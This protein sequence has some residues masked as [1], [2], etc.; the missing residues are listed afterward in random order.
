M[1]QDTDV[2]AVALPSVKSL[3][4]KFESKD[5]SPQGEDQQ[6]ARS[7]QPDDVFENDPETGGAPDRRWVT[8]HNSLLR[9]EPKSP[10]RQQPRKPPVTAAS[11][12]KRL[13][14]IG[15]SPQDQD[16]AMEV[17]LMTDHQDLRDKSRSEA[18]LRI[19]ASQ[20]QEPRLRTNATARQRPK[21]HRRSK[22]EPDP[23]SVLRFHAQSSPPSV[24]K[25][26][27]LFE[28]DAVPDRSHEPP[29]LSPRKTQR[30]RTPDLPQ[31]V[32]TSRKT[33]QETTVIETTSAEVVH[34]VVSEATVPTKITPQEKVDPLLHGTPSVRSLR[35]RFEIGDSDQPT[36]PTAEPSSRPSRA[37]VNT[38]KTPFE[39]PLPRQARSVSPDKQIRTSLTGTPSASVK[40][41]LKQFEALSP[42]ESLRD[43]SGSPAV[44]E[45]SRRSPL[46][47]SPKKQKAQSLDH[48]VAQDQHDA[49]AQDKITVRAEKDSKRRLLRQSRTSGSSSSSKSSSSS[50][51]DEEETKDNK[52]TERELER[53]RKEE[54]KE[55]Q[56][57]EQEQRALEQQRKE[58][59]EKERKAREEKERKE[60]EEKAR[61]ERE[62]KEKKEREEKERKE[63]EEKARKEREERERKE[64]EEKARKDREERERKEREEKVRKEREEKQKKERE[65]K[66]RKEREEKARKERE[67]RKRPLVP[68]AQ[69]SRHLAGAAEAGARL[70]PGCA[71]CDVVH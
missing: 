71:L 28:K 23:S 10:E 7:G 41:L 33:I 45:S 57:T 63:R 19:M 36:R 47:D 64:R 25:L 42:V 15:D 69:A 27:M 60:R 35:W 48:A 44:D 26:K 14:Q 12:T 20:A 13:Q 6:S 51:S 49:R 3:R 5:S 59:E 22:S 54:E 17:F 70:Y 53:R 24:K 1:R 68:V 37:A 32:T 56:R 9:R 30:E 43:A 52:Q 61:K 46:K 67:E 21:N 39:K 38:L 16:E 11:V 66:E 4:G 29:P 18:S 50:S 40:N 8:R 34:L 62:E 55:R 58:K 65:E 2:K 31:A